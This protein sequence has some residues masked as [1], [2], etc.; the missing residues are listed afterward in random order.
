MELGD[1]G[2]CKTDGLLIRYFPSDG[3]KVSTDLDLEGGGGFEALGFLAGLG[4]DS[5]G[6]GHFVL[7]VPKAGPS[8]GVILGSIGRWISSTTLG[9]ERY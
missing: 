5:E 6:E 1:C 4:L 3:E 2:T 9:Y 8:V 7:R